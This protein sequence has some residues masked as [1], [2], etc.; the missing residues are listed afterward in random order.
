MYNG[1]LYK[2][3][4]II[5][6]VV[7]VNSKPRIRLLNVSKGCMSMQVVEFLERLNPETE[8]ILALSM[9]LFAGFIMTRLTNT[10][11][12]PKEF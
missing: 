11:N 2:Y 9:I 12:M 1:L 8:V 5:N 6:A 7:E 4:Q 10:L 3:L